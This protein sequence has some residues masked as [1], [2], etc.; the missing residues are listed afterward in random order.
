MMNEALMSELCPRLK[1]LGFLDVTCYQ[2]NFVHDGVFFRISKTVMNKARM[3]EKVVF[4]QFVT[5][6]LISEFS[7]DELVYMLLRKFN[8]EIEKYTLGDDHLPMASY[9]TP[10]R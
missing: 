6:S 2:D 8:K 5:N 3:P 7:I 4:E 1:K 9:E 10:V